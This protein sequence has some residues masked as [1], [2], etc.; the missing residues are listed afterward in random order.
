LINIITK[1]KYPDIWD[2]ITEDFDEFS[3]KEHRRGSNF[4]VT[5]IHTIDQER[6]PEH[7]GLWGIW[8]S[9]TY[10]YDTEYGTDEVPETL[11]RVELVTKEKVV[12]VAEWVRVND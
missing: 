1:D 4:Y 9:G 7:P 11:H 6:F 2:L 10:I 3:S 5:T 8:E 12:K